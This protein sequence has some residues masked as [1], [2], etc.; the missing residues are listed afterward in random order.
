MA[1]L[2]L[3]AFR[4]GDEVLIGTENAISSGGGNGAQEVFVPVVQRVVRASMKDYMNSLDDVHEYSME[5]AVW[6]ISLRTTGQKN[7]F[8]EETFDFHADIPTG[9]K[10]HT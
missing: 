2:G 9:G 8:Q 6:N 7:D 4:G 1:E 10:F 3:Q 5:V